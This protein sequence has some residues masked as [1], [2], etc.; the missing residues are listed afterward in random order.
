[1]KPIADSFCCF[2]SHNTFAS[3]GS[4]GTISVWDHTAKKRMKQYSHLPTEVSGLA[5]SQDGTKL[6]IACSY[7]QDNGIDDAELSKRDTI[8]LIIKDGVIDDCRVSIPPRPLVASL[9]LTACDSSQRPRRRRSKHEC[10]QSTGWLAPPAEMTIER[11]R[12][13]A[14]PWLNKVPRVHV[15]LV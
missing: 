3:G 13:D 12:Y 5:F 10:Y 6:A 11:A 7:E 9:R 1:M 4:D 14:N 2:R 8:A 15:Y